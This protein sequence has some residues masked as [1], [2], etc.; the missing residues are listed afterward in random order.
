MSKELN[1]TICLNNQTVGNLKKYLAGFP[2]DARV[3]ISGI[4]ESYQ[5]HDCQI[6][7]NFEQQEKANVV[8]FIPGS[9]I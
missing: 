4:G 2:D 3:I 5:D 7:C 6:A 1:E 9:L 8:Q